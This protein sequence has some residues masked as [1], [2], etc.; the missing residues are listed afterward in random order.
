MPRV[1]GG[2]EGFTRRT[3]GDLVAR[4]DD[5]PCAGAKDGLDALDVGVLGGGNQRADRV[6]RILE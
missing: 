2:E 1:V 6:F 5:V 4:C 3:I